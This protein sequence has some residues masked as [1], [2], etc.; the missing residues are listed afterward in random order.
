MKKLL[1]A[2]AVLV[3]PTTMALASGSRQV[4]QKVPLTYLAW[5][6]G[7]KEEPSLDR[8]MLLAFQEAHPDVALTIL[9][10]PTNADGTA[11]SYD[12]Y[13]NSLAAQAN[14]PDVFMW[15]SVPDTAA[16][17]WSLNVSD[18]ALNDPDFQRVTAALRENSKVN[19]HVYAF[20]SSMYLY[21]M[22][23]NQTIFEELNVPPLPFSYTID[24][25]RDRIARTTTDKYKGI[26]NFAIEDWGAFTLDSK[27]GFGTF[28]GERYNYTSD[29]Y[30]SVIGIYQ[31]V[32]SRRQTGNGNIVEPSSWLPEGAGWAWG[33]GYIALQYEATW[34]LDG[35]VNGDRP[36][37]ADI[38]PLPGEKA[39]LVPDFIY[40]GANTKQTA[41]AYELAKWMSFGADGQKKRV[42]IAKAAGKNLDRMPIAPGAYPE[43]DSYY[44]QNYRSLRNFI[45]LYE[46]IQQKPENVIVEGYKVVPGYE[47]SRYTADTGVLGMVG[48]VQKSMTMNELVMS[49]VRGERQLA[50]YAAEMERIANSEYQ[51]AAAAVRDK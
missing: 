37:K 16:R 31:D 15:T 51:R 43:I 47:R 18:Y 46:M 11:G 35:F 17:G 48:G 41:L 38:L 27:L 2:L 33:E 50:D 8:E 40:V 28:D 26:D 42:E 19:G 9:E 3:F 13:L 5:N 23:V 34:S 32:A 49:I 36:F 22:A 12:N 25:L 4:G 44:L 1:L 6:L 20:P 30:A 7:T 24:D 45:Q 10:V 29:A 39:V 21:G 14:L